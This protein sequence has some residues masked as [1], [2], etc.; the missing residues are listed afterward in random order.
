MKPTVNDVANTIKI[1]A[2]DVGIAWDVISH[3]YDALDFVELKEFNDK[4][5]T[6][7]LGLLVS[8]LKKKISMDF[9]NY[10]I[11]IDKGQKTLKDFGYKL[12]DEKG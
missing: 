11:S 1:D 9:A 4:S 2:A 3:Q 6:V 10:M 8:S 5:K 12:I 7:T